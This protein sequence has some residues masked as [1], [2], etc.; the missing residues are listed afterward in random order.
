MRISMLPIFV[1][2][3]FIKTRLDRPVRSVEPGIDL[4]SGPGQ[5]LK[6]FLRSNRLKIRMEWVIGQNRF[7][8]KQNLKFQN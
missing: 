2:N 7:Y 4:L 5:R 6:Q 1:Y 8:E 3:N